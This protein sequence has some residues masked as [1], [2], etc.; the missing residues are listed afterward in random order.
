MFYIITTVFYYIVIHQVYT[1]A[2]TYECPQEELYIIVS[3]KPLIKR[4]YTAYTC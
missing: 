4:L 1:A 2:S 3:Y